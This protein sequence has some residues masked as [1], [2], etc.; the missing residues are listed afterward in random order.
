MPSVGAG[1][2]TVSGC[3]S[4]S[5]CVVSVRCREGV[6][7]RLALI[8]GSERAPSGWAGESAG[9]AFSEPGPATVAW[10]GQLPSAP[11]VLRTP[12]HPAFLSGGRGDTPA[13]PARTRP[14]VARGA[15]F[16]AEQWSFR[17]LGSCP[18]PAGRGVLDPHGLPGMTQAWPP[19][20]PLLSAVAALSK[21]IRGSRM[22]LRSWSASHPSACENAMSGEALVLANG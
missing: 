14:P 12:L 15:P 16:T 11:G 2:S 1:P 21:C 6:K 7:G 4:S 10:R 18:C 8:T 20:S 22:A 19:P 9:P 5:E 17:P 13:A 3:K